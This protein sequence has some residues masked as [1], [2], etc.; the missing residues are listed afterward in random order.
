MHYLQRRTT[1]RSINEDLDPPRKPLAIIRSH[2]APLQAF[3]APVTCTERLRFKCR[4]P[5]S[6]TFHQSQILHFNRVGSAQ[7]S[8]LLFKTEAFLFIQM[9]KMQHVRALQTNCSSQTRGSVYGRVQHTRHEEATV[10]AACRSRGSRVP[11]DEGQASL[12]E[13]LVTVHICRLLLQPRRRFKVRSPTC[14]HC[15]TEEGQSMVVTVSN[16]F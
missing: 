12:G 3:S 1:D 16:V 9:G 13:A 7:N 8:P 15:P 6:C 4:P 2:V 11:L 10:G 5:L 14:N